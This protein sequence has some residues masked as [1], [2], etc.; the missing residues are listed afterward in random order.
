M[1]K[2]SMDNN[3][4]DTTDVEQMA[5]SV[6]AVKKGKGTKANKATTSPPSSSTT[7]ST[8]DESN[9]SYVDE[10]FAELKNEINMLTKRIEELE[11][12]GVSTVPSKGAKKEK[13]P[14]EEK[15]QR[16][17]TAYNIFMKTKMV[18]LKETRPELN[19]IERMKM[20]AEAWSESKK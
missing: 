19:N 1:S 4:E 17:P 9:T 14:K 18:E 15:K 10:K 16:A 20:A 5:T 8:T 6:V 2:N 11:T 12:K 7:T 13:E 3:V